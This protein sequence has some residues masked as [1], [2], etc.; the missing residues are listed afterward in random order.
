MDALPFIIAG[1]LV[2]ILVGAT[3]V[4]GGSLMTPIL[5][6][7]FGVP[8]SAAVGTDLL[9]ASITKGV[10]T[11]LH[12]LNQSISWKVVGRLAAG[13]LPA[14]LGTLWLLHN[15]FNPKT[16]AGLI[17]V[18]LG[19][20]LVLTSLAIF[21]QPLFRKW[22]AK[23]QNNGNVP[24]ETPS[25]MDEA[26]RLAEEAA[27]ESRPES[28]PLTVAIGFVLGALVTI[29]S[30]GAGALGVMVLM[31]IYPKVRSVRIVGTDIA[32]AVPLT[33]VAGL[34]HAS[35]GAVNYG[36]LGSLL[37]GSIP[38]IAVGSHI[39]FR[40]PE[41]ALKRTLACILMVVGGRLI[42]P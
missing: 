5:V 28:A 31:A 33:L 29:T 20:A 41:K 38:G 13:S 14:A 6:I 10:G 34:G 1:L 8:A 42:L 26:K 4:G 24:S 21:F 2:G 3:G 9:F 11:G 22:F 23:T 7:I 18:T 19:F 25:A 15:V 27:C 32:H 16:V 35:M 40:L 39:A 36:M 12:G 30:V 37:L 17:T